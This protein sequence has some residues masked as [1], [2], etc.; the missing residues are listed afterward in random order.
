MPAKLDNIDI[1]LKLAIAKRFEEIRKKGFLKARVD[2]EII[3]LRPK[4]QVDRYKIHDIEVVVDRI[5]VN[6]AMKIRLG[7]SVS[8]CLKMGKDLL[9]AWKDR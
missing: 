2:G 9:E 8:Q 4:F 5:P 1:S 7:E 6:A 3:E